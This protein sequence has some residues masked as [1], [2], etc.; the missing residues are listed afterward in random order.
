MSLVSAKVDKQI[1]A[2]YEL[3][4]NYKSEFNFASEDR[5]TYPRNSTPGK[6]NLAPVFG[7]VS[8]E[9]ESRFAQR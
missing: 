6:R 9:G 2:K 4:S 8:G 1:T 7:F 5:W 3:G